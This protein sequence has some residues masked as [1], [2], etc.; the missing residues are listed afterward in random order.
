MELEKRPAKEI[1][2]RKFR[3]SWLDENVF[4]GWLAQNNNEAFCTICNI[5]LACYRSTLVKH[6]KSISHIDNVNSSDN[7]KVDT[8]IE[9]TVSHSDKVKRAEIKL[10]AFFAEHNIA[11][12][13]VDHL[14]PLL[15][16]ICVDPEVV[17]SF[18]LARTKCTQIVKNVI[19][20]R[21]VE[22]MIQN[23]QISKFSILIDESTDISDTKLF[24]DS[25]EGISYVAGTFQYLN[26]VSSH[27]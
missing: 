12:C 23:L 16:D 5:S 6:A 1:C 2:I 13:I 4:K 11:F 7:V 27:L 15:K 21:E 25:T 18:S 10:A 14:V 8:S 26:C 17:Q 24:P 3:K 9:E 22:K 19:A 20:Q